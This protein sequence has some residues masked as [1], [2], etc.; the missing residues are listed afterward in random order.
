MLADGYVA[1]PL[2]ICSEDEL[3]SQVAAEVPDVAARLLGRG[4]AIELPP[5]TEAP[6]HPQSLEPW[7]GP[8]SAS[9]L[10]RVSERCE[11]IDRVACALLF[12]DQDDRLLLVG[13]DVSTLAMVISEDPQLID[14]YRA[15]CEELSPAEYLALV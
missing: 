14:R 11:T 4:S 7:S 3:A 15:S 5:A 1:R 6:S 8:Y 13:T 10:L 9:V 2:T 12:I